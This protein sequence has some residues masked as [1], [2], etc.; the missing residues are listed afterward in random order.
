MGFTGRAIEEPKSPAAH[1]A[2]QLLSI[3]QQA[4]EGW[5]LLV[6]ALAEGYSSAWN[7][8]VAV[9]D[10]IKA[11]IQADRDR[12]CFI[13]SI[14]TA[15]VAG[16]LLGGVASGAVRTMGDKTFKEAFIKNFL[17]NAASDGASQFGG[18]AVSYFQ[19]HGGNPFASPG[20]E[21]STYS[22]TMQKNVRLLFAGFHDHLADIVDDLESG[23]APAQDGE[24]WYQYYRSSPLIQS[25]P[26]AAD[27]NRYDFERDASLCLWIAWGAQR[28]FAYWNEAWRA[29]EDPPDFGDSVRGNYLMKQIKIDGYRSDM[30]NWDPIL[31][32]IRQ[33][34]P[35]L[36]MRVKRSA[37]VTFP[38]GNLV[39]ST[40]ITK[41]ETHIDLRTL[42]SLGFYSR[43]KSAQVMSGYLAGAPLMTPEGAR[44]LMLTM[45]DIPRMH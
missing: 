25:F 29:I 38:T 16:G 4:E 19:S 41:R 22:A 40:T 26:S 8:Q 21:P 39:F 13:L 34:D 3:F 6:D 7:R 37:N 11:K 33:I 45:T 28:D 17:T 35:T 36:E 18:S 5:L 31:A 1:R 42:K 14:L 44:R 27:V 24:Q 10:D 20:I 32:E 30:S 12:A 2:W 43:I 23:K 9:L 15:G